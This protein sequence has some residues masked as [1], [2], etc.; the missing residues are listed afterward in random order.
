MEPIVVIRELY[1]LLETVQGMLTAY[2]EPD[3]PDA[4]ET[5]GNLLGVVDGPEQ[6]RIQQAA[7]ISLIGVSTMEQFRPMLAATCLHPEALHY[8]VLATPKLDGIRCLKKDGKALTRSLKPIPN[9]YVRTWIEAEFPNGIDGELI[10][11]GKK[12]TD[13][14]SLV[15]SIKGTVGFSSILHWTFD[16]VGDNFK[17]VDRVYRNRMEDLRT[18][19][20][21]R[22]MVKLLPVV[23][24]NYGELQEFECKCVEGGYE[25]ICLRDPDSPYKFGRSTERQGWLLKIKRFEDSEAEII[26]FEEKMHNSNV[27]FRGE[28][29]QAKRATTMEGMVPMDTLGA[30]LVR[31]EKH[32][33]TFSVGS[34][35]DDK[36]RRIIWQ[37]RKAYMGKMIKYK[38]QPY[39]VKNGPR[40]PIFLGFRDKRDL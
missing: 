37:D 39:G 11:P 24:H 28:L 26:G 35:F 31:D 18:L 20:S 13:V 29:G 3:G 38:F 1:G 10:L 4:Y 21:P 22:G 8:P 17:L 14:S 34:G 12:F 27:M 30:L 40:S 25:G 2:L 36:R 32:Y 23:L 5:I 16:Y 33:W 19:V 7:K 15:M 9:I 6:R